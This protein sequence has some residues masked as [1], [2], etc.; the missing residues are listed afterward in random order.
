MMR[1]ISMQSSS[2]MSPEC[3]TCFTFLRSRGGSLS[4]LMT[5]ADAEGTTDTFAWRFCTVSFTV[6]RRPFQS[7]LVSL[8]MSSPTFLGDRPRGPIFGASEEA[9]PT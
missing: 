1:A 2:E 8:A 9:A 5:S 3:F 6:T 4:A 7:F